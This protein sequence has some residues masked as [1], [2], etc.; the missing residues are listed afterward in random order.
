[1][2]Y[3]YSVASSP[4]VCTC[5]YMVIIIPWHLTDL[6]NLNE[7]IRDGARQFQIKN[8]VYTC[9]CTLYHH[10]CRSPGLHN[11]TIKGSRNGTYHTI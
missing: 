6:E 1:M 8:D 4:V 9:T 5:T 7:T 11:V 2:P 3:P 10:V